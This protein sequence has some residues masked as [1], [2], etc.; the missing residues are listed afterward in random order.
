MCLC[1]GFVWLPTSFCFVSFVF[2]SQDGF[3]N[4]W[5]GGALIKDLMGS[6]TSLLKSLP[7]SPHFYFGR[8]CGSFCDL[9]PPLAPPPSPSTL[10]ALSWTRLNWFE[11]FQPCSITLPSLQ[12]PSTWACS[13]H[14]SELPPRV[15]WVPCKLSGPFL[16]SSWSPFPQTL[17]HGVLQP[18]NMCRLL[19]LG[20]S[21]SEWRIISHPSH[22]VQCQMWPTVSK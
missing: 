22:T 16:R 19:N 5:G 18:A 8:F 10:P 1:Q 21:S 3:S 9:A 13:R 17:F 15:P 20:K 2:R 12:R 7:V 14:S 11:P 6:L 4:T